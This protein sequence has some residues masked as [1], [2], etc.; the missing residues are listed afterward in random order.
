M[1][2][3]NYNDIKK[4][5]KQYSKILRNAN[6]NSYRLYEKIS[7][8]LNHSLQSNG[9]ETTA[10]KSNITKTFSSRNPKL[11]VNENKYYPIKKC[12]YTKFLELR[13][14]KNTVPFGNT[15]QRFKWQNLK[16]E[17]IVIYPEI[18]KKP[19][20]KQFL[21]KETFGEGML[22]FINY[23]KTNDDKPKIRRIR[24]C[25]SE[26][27]LD[28][29]NHIQ[30]IDINISKRV[31]DPSYNKEPEKTIKKKSFSQSNFNYHKTDGGLK[32]L[33]DLTP[34]DIPIKGKKLYKTKSYGAININL[35]DK[36]YGQ[37]EMPTHT[38]KQFFNN[39]CYFDHIKDQDLISDMN[40]FWKFK[41]SKS[42][43]PGFK[44]D[45][46]LY[47]NTN[48][49]QLQ[50]RNN[51]NNSINKRDINNSLSKINRNIRNNKNEKC[52]YKFLPNLL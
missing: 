21:L 52:N 8:S 45:L 20:K 44:T 35:F 37:F 23:K 31:I 42:V 6:N 16:N 33:F 25:L 14:I 43:V 51:R 1:F 30:N 24:R 19:H 32:S 4:S 39:R 46:E 17:N 29:R 2:N 13:N 3:I 22:D 34:I 9:T 10:S 7:F 26:Q 15:E 49:D 11:R 5:K 38:K 41:R 50:L 40:K 12:S 27:D 47:L 18:Y 36:N 48:V 28:K